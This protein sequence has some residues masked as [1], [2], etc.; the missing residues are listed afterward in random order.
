MRIDNPPSIAE[1]AHAVSPGKLT[2]GLRSRF[3]MT[4]NQ[5]TRDYRR[6]FDST[7]RQERREAKP[8]DRRKLKPP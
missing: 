5:Y 8:N 7:P 1:L 4:I 6:E 3:G 2:R